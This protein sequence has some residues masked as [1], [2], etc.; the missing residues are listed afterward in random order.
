VEAVSWRGV[1][2][3]TFQNKLLIMS[4]SVIGKETIE[5]APRDNLNARLVFFNTMYTYSP[6]KTIQVVR[7]AV[8]QV[9]NV[10]QKIRPIVRIKSLGDSSIDWEVKYWAE[11]YAKYNDTDALIKQ[12]IWYVFNREKIDFAYPTRSIYIQN[13]PQEETPSEYVN[14]TSEYL[15]RVP[16]FAPLSEDELEKLAKAS[17]D[18]IFAPGEAIVRKGQ[19]GNS[20]FV[21]TRGSVKVQIPQNDKVRTINNLHEND[22]FGEM[23]LLTGEPRSATVVAAE[24]TTVIQI[25][26]SGLKSIFEANPELVKSICDLIE[27]RQLLLKPET[28]ETYDNEETTSR[29][30]MKSIRNFFGLS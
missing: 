9:E 16:I 4:N 28:E 8:R 24:E 23:S 21:I 10:S 11:D 5:V 15:G 1:K 17:N 19:E 26:K 29:G 25:R 13:E 12:R 2:I 3:R 22:F 7:E 30:V 14:S 6:S 18:R 20:M 27:E